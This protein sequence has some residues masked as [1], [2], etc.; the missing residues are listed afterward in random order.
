VAAENRLDILINMGDVDENG[1][2]NAKDALKVLHASLDKITLEGNTFG[3]ADVDG[4][5]E[6]TS[7]DAL[8]LL[9]FI[10]GKID[11][12]PAQN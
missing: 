7:T 5:N 10:V 11:T 1:T 3:Y 9:Q 8:I 12:F 6:I 2:I 4:D